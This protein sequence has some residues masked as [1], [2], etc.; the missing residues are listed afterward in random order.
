[1][2]RTHIK[3]SLFLLSYLPLFLIMIVLN[4]NNDWILYS[5]I[6]ASLIGIIGFLLLL[7]W[8]QKFSGTPQK[9]N[10]IESNNKINFEYFIAYIIPF[11]ALDIQSERQLLAY[12]ILFVV[13]G[14][15][16]VRSNLIYV[17]PTLTLI[18]YNIFKIEVDEDESVL[19]TRSNKTNA[20][21]KPI[22]LIDR[23][24]YIG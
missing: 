18:G 16:Y 21:S 10:K 23:G 15:L 7:I 20:L 5:A 19:L 14:T 24:L 11:V 2:L 6:I 9:I 13:I 12:G 1:M 8:K 4:P 3:I 22:L 17:N